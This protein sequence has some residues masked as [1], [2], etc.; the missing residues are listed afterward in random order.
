MSTSRVPGPL[1]RLARRHGLT[2]S[3]LRRNTDR[4]EA[5]VTAGAA[6]LVVFAALLA[7]VVAMGI[8]QRAQTEAATKA[9]RQTSVTAVLLTDAA[10]QGAAGPAIAEV[11]W[12][13]PNGQQRTAPLS[14]DT[15][16]RAGD[17]ISIWIDQRGNRVDPPKTSGTMIADAVGLGILFL[18]GGWVLL[19]SLWWTAC[20]V[21]DRINATRWDLDWERTGP[22]W[23]RQTWQ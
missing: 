18:T 19:G 14:V 2:R 20:R 9:A 8:Y 13:L 11:R 6:V 10:T 5:W 17:R 7:A 21:L 4:V 23:N 12:P 3:P 15:D 1:T 16:H 22:G